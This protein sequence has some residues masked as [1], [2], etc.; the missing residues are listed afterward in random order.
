[1]VKLPRSKTDQEGRGQFVPLHRREGKWC[2]VRALEEWGEASYRKG[3]IFVALRGRKNGCQLSPQ[4]V[5]R[6]LRRRLEAVGLVADDYGAHSLRSGLVVSA[7]E[8]GA[9]ERTIMAVTRHR[10][11]AGLAP[12]LAFA[13]TFAEDP[14]GVAGFH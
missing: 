10:T 13:D 11:L 5:W 3:P 2:P 7:R 1:V 8:R 12:Y 6:I 9:S 4:G 14:A